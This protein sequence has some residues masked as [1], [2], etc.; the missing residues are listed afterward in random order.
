MPPGAVF[1]WTAGTAPTNKWFDSGNIVIEGGAASATYE[2]VLA[3][4][5]A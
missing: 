1:L 5:K 2:I 3:G 4:V